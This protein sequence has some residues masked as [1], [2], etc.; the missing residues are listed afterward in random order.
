MHVVRNVNNQLTITTN[1]DQNGDIT[2]SNTLG[3][4]L[5]TLPTT[6]NYTIV[7]EAFIADVYLISLEINAVIRTAKVILN[8]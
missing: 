3:E 6:G 1:P 7:N 5:K 2:I 8:Q 4:K